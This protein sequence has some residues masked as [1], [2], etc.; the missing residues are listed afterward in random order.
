MGG[1]WGKKKRSLS[2]CGPCDSICIHSTHAPILIQSRCNSVSFRRCKGSLLFNQILLNKEFC[3]GPRGRCMVL[4]TGTAQYSLHSINC[5]YPS[6]YS[7]RHEWKRW[8]FFF[9]CRPGTPPRKLNFAKSN[10]RY[11]LRLDLLPG[12]LLGFMLITSK[13][14]K[15]RLITCSPILPC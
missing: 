2:S 10:C 13:A 5:H 12:E 7:P 9:F 3:P 1:G 15:L 6:T 14:S 8:I 4:D 11:F